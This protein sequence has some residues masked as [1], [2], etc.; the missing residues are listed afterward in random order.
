MEY[1]D[2]VG[3]CHELLK[4]F[5]GVPEEAHGPESGRR[6]LTQDA[7]VMRKKQG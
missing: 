3:L 2:D 1:T 6:M 4:G 5:M 7:V